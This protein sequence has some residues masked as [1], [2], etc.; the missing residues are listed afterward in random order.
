MGGSCARSNGWT[1]WSRP[2]RESM[3]VDT[4][5]K[6]VTGHG[7]DAAHF[8]VPGAERGAGP[9]RL[10]SVGRVTP[11]KD[12]LTVV[13]ALNLLR[14]EGSTSSCAGPAARWP[15]DDE[16][17]GV[18]RQSDRGEGLESAVDFVGAVPYPDVPALYRDCDLF[19]NASRTGSVDKVVL[20][21]MAA[22]R[23][24]VSCNES[25]PPLLDEACSPSTARD[26]Y[27]FRPGDPESLASAI[28]GGSRWTPARAPSVGRPRADGEERARRRR[29]H[30]AADPDDGGAPRDR[31]LDRLPGRR[32][33]RRGRGAPTRRPRASEPKVRISRAPRPAGG[34]R[35]ARSR[36]SGPR[37]A[38]RPRRARRRR[39]PRRPR[40]RGRGPG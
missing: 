3:R 34:P 37:G 9:L 25:I 39:G 13:E 33:D 31:P 15:G 35:P 40:P 21:A 29:P 2:P 5:K 38:S 20:E 24:F 16:Y 30:G 28:R 22:S 4:P 27:A 36:C 19:V 14:Q 17:A 11:A 6:I 8:D 10:L 26:D 12:P 1:V 32:R 7:I 18:V 23:P